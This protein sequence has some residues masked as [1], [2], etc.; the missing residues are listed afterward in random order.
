[1]AALFVEDRNRIVLF[2]RKDST[3]VVEK[4]LDEYW[5]AEVSPKPF[6][7]TIVGAFR[8]GKEYYFINDLS[9]VFKFKNNDFTQ[10]DEVGK[11]IS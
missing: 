6:D 11:V 2:V 4:V 8:K 5:D 1:M 10:Y 7:T 9:R 3:V